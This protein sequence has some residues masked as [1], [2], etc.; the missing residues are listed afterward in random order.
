MTYCPYS[1]TLSHSIGLTCSSNDF[2]TAGTDP[3]TG[4]S[5]GSLSI[6]GDNNDTYAFHTGGANLT[7]GDGSVRFVPNS[8]NI[9]F[10]ARLVTAH[11]EEVVS[12]TDF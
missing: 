5:G 4:A 9:R 12:G 1:S 7:F 10:W 8:L 6:N 2:G 3:L 11:A